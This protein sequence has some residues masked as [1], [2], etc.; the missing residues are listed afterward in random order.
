[1]NTQNKRHAENATAT[2]MAPVAGNAFTLIELLV[3]IAI[4]A[5]LAAMLL[6]ALAK[7]KSKAQ[8]IA[9]LSNVRQLQLAWTMYVEDSNET[10]P[11]NVEAFSPP[12]SQPGSWVLGNAQTDTTTSNIVNGSLFKYVKG[13]GVYRCPGDKSIVKGSGTAHTRS[14]SLSV[15]LNGYTDGLSPSYALLSSPAN[16]PLHKTKL[17]QLTQPTPGSTF[18]FMEENELSI[19]DGMMVIENPMYGPW[20]D[21]WDMPSDRHNGIGTVSFADSHVESVKWRYPKRYLNHGQ[22]VVSPYTPSSLDWQDFRR[23]QSW[24]P[25]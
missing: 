12:A 18:V 7:A 6:P 11:L 3:V 24:V 15:W 19:D 2:T 8:G 5:I 23:A 14:Y 22:S 16:D 4:I 10:F 17:N 9:C 21:W 20:N 1:M 25:Q 13:T